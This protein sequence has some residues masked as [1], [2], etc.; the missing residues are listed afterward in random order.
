MPYELDRKAAL[1]CLNSEIETLYQLRNSVTPVLSRVLDVLQNT[2][3]HVIV[4]GMG[5]SGHIGRKIAASLSSTGTPSFF[6]HPAE[7]SHGDIGM[8]TC[9]DALIAI[10]NSGES[11]ELTDIISYC[12]QCRVFIIAVTK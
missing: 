8:I 9:N 7:A 3:G 12:K 2:K 1:S 11:K 10:S 5:K 6:L 4:T